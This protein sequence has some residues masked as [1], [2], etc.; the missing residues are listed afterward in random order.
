MSVVSVVSEATGLSMASAGLC[1]V[2]GGVVVVTLTSVLV[3]WVAERYQ[4]VAAREAVQRR[5]C[6]SRIRS[7]AKVRMRVD[8]KVA[9]EWMQRWQPSGSGLP[10]TRCE[11]SGVWARPWMT[12]AIARS[13]QR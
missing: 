5:G 13:S 9:A 7:D 2:L 4:D 12:D 1:C 3:V 10:G 11:S 6:A 8:A